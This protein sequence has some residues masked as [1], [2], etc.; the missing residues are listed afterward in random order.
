MSAVAD[1][2]FGF[3]TMCDTNAMVIQETSELG[4]AVDK[5]MGTQQKFTDVP[6]GTPPDGRYDKVRERTSSTQQLVSAKLFEVLNSDITPGYKGGNLK[7]CI[8]KVS[9]V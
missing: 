6:G 3:L 7:S 9:L 2:L 1:K 4:I 8:D 5:V